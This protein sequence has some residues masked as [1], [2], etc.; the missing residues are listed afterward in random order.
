MGELDHAYCQKCPGHG[1]FRKFRAGF[2][3]DVPQL[4]AKLGSVRNG[5]RAIVV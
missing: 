3:Y 4:G 1:L 2:L 5:S